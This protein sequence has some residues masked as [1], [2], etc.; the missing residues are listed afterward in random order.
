MLWE[1]ENEN[2]KCRI[3][4]AQS[5]AEKCRHILSR[6][7]SPHCTVQNVGHRRPS[8]TGPRLCIGFGQSIDQIHLR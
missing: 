8:G 6:Y 1:N 7:R 3:D 5:H 4:L 2:E